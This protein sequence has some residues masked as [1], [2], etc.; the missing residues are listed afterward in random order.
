[1]STKLP[2]AFVDQIKARA[3]QRID[4]LGLHHDEAM[5]RHMF[6]ETSLLAEDGDVYCP[7][8]VARGQPTLLKT[9]RFDPARLSCGQC[10]YLVDLPEQ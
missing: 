10:G 9:W 2:P 3:Q 5:R 8:C 4:H 7:D 6:A 1:M